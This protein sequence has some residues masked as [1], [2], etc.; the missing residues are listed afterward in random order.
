MRIQRRPPAWR[1]HTVPVVLKSKGTNSSLGWSRPLESLPPSQ[2]A[3]V[4]KHPLARW[5]E[6]PIVAFAWIS[7]FTGHLHETVVE[8]Q[9]VS[10]RVLPRWKLFAVVWKTTFDEVADFAESEF[11]LGRLQNSHCNQCD[12]GIGRFWHGRLPSVIRA[13]LACV[14]ILFCFFF[15][16][17]FFHEDIFFVVVVAFCCFKTRYCYLLLVFVFVI[18]LESH[19]G[20]QPFQS[21]HGVS[22][23]THWS[24]RHWVGLLCGRWRRNDVFSVGKSCLNKSRYTETTH[25]SYNHL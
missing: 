22:C 13:L 17:F 12:I 2:E 14:G 20:A 1:I 9:V 3:A 7:R 18:F 16:W 24:F 19:R 21:L 6:C 4:V 8:R 15:C 5:V 11:S 10:N 25:L 23:C